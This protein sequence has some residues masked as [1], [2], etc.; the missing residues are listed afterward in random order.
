[1]AALA[2]LDAIRTGASDRPSSA[3]YF[4][5]GDVLDKLGRYGEASA[6]YVSANRV[7][8]QALPYRY[9][10]SGQ[11]AQVS[12]LMSYFKRDRLSRLT[13]LTHDRRRAS[14][15]QAPQPIFIVGFPRSGTTLT[16][17]ILASHPSISAGDELDYLQRL[18]SLAPHLCGIAKPYP[19][20]LDALAQPQASEASLKKFRDYYV[21]NAELRGVAAPGT[22]WFTDKMP[23]NEMHLGLIHL[24][25]PSSPIIH[26]IRHPL[27]VVLSTFFTDLTHGGYCSYELETA[28][29]HY[30]LVFELIEH[31]RHE[32]DLN[33]LPVRYEDLVDD[34]EPQVRRLLDFIGEPYDAR[35]VSFDENP[36]YARTA[37]YAQVSEKLY[38]RSRFRYRNYLELLGPVIPILQPA[39]D[40]LGYTV[41]H[42]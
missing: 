27:D 30:A 35:C 15:A 31:Y 38:T 39:I 5:R 3:Y 26:L 23:L 24:A 11:R 7:A 8:Q 29:K 6:S 18:T 33:Y 21:C 10:E 34:P 16:E 4:E 17:Q 22:K 12:R 42:V 20:C 36:R 9:N 25:F 40:R 13:R 19:D 28:A 14:P 41:E 37:S 2:A 1:M 32:M